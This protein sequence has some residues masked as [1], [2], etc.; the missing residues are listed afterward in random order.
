MKIRHD[1]DEKKLFPGVGVGLGLG[2]GLFYFKNKDVLK[3][4]N[5]QSVQTN[6]KTIEI[7]PLLFPFLFFKKK[8]EIFFP[9][10]YALIFLALL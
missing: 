8:H 6:I 7:S 1:L 9:P 2:W 5:I 4:I 3:P 10:L